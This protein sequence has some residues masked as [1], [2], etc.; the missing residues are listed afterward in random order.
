MS[1]SLSDSNRNAK[2][3]AENLFLRADKMRDRGDLRSAFRLFL[4]A[5]K[6]GYRAVQLNVSCTNVIF[7]VE[8]ARRSFDAAG[9][10]WLG[11]F[12]RARLAW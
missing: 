2:I 4:A 11:G 8:I 5:A 12:L 1:R 3:A 10:S 6:A 7:V 9:I